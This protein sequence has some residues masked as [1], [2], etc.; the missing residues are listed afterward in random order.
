LFAGQQAIPISMKLG[1]E[2]SEAIITMSKKKALFP[3]K[4]QVFLLLTS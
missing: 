2:Y 4:A 1:K 3:V